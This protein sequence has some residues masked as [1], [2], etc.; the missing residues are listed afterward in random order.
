MSD[1]ETHKGKLKP[2]ELTKEEVVKEY[3]MNYDSTNSYT[4]N[5]KKELEKTGSLDLDKIT[6]IFPDIEE[7]AEINGKIY[8]IQDELFDDSNDIFEMQE[9][10][11]GTLKYMVKFYN[12]GCGFEEALGI[13][14]NKMNNI[15]F[16]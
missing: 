5:N 12:G 1:Y 15:V 8:E 3:L 16:K 9:N 4:L 7:Y 10:P 14:S 6:E 13:A 11:D 2:T